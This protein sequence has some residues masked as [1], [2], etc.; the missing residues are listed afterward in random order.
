MIGGCSGVA[1]GPP[2]LQVGALLREL[3]S[4]KLV[5][6]LG[7]APRSSAYRAGALL[8][9]Y[10]TE[11]AKARTM[12]QE[13]QTP[14]PPRDRRR[15]LVDWWVLVVTLHP[16]ASHNFCDSG[17]TDRLQEQHPKLVAGAGNAPALQEYE[18]RV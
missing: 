5:V 8:L 18:P 15:R 9:S 10:G 1:P 12:G 16:S 2:T 3:N 6:L 13:R 7:N 11:M 4:Q 17:F 14:L